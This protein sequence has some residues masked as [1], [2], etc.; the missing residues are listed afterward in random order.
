MVRWICLAVAALGLGL[1]A[2]GWH[3]NQHA[4][5]AAPLLPTGGATAGLITHVQELDGKLLRVIMI[6][7]SQRVMGVYEIARDTGEIQIKSIRN[8][9]ADFQMLE[10]NSGTLSPADIQKTLERK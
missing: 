5:F 10:Y 3:T 4:A 2:S 8:F 6:D 7:P 1:V 9:H